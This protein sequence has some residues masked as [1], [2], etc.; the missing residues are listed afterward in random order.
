MRYDLSTARKNP[1]A[2]RLKKG[3][4]IRI[5]VPPEE[6]SHKEINNFYVTDEEL[7]IIKEFV[8]SEERKRG[9][10]RS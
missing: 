9:L 2:E 6:E 10:V 5:N 1:Y 8:A 3:Y 4:S 7:Q